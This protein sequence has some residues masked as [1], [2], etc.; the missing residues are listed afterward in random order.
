MVLSPPH[1]FPP[2]SRLEAIQQCRAVLMVLSP[3]YAASPGFEAEREMVINRM[4]DPG[5]WGVG[6]GGG[7]KMGAGGGGGGGGGAYAASPGSEVE[8]EL[9]G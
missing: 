8:R 2:S 7:G 6:W 1:P 3:A 5:V 4:L 9:V